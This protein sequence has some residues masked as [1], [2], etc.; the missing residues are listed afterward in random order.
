MPAQLVG[1]HWKE[2]SW[3]APYLE[4]G[5][6][7]AGLWFYGGGDTEGGAQTNAVNWLLLRSKP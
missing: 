7:S 2:G 3:L 6:V 5:Q 1:M 4:K